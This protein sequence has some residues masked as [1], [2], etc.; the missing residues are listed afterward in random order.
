MK[1]FKANA[2]EYDWNAKTVADVRRETRIFIANG[3]KLVRPTTLLGR[4]LHWLNQPCFS[5]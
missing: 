1:P 5:K 3:R 2:A 4:I